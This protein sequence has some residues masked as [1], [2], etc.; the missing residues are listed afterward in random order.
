VRPDGRRIRLIGGRDLLLIRRYPSC[1]L[2]LLPVYLLL[3]VCLCMCVYVYVCLSH[4]LSDALSSICSLSFSS[5]IE[6]RTRRSLFFI[7]IRAYQRKV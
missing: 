5:A 3:Y 6:S 4:R 2:S 1:Y 7:S